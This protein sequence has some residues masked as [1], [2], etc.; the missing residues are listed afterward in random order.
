MKLSEDIEKL[1]Q[2]Q[3]KKELGAV[4]TYLGMAAH[5]ESTPYEGF[6][7]WMHKQVKEEMGHAMKF[8][9]YLK[10]RGNSIKLQ[11]I[12]APKCTFSSPLEAFEVALKHEQGVTKSI[13]NIYEA[14]QK[15]KDFAT[16]QFLDWFIKEQVEEESTASAFIQKLTIAKDHVGAL[17]GLDSQAGK[18][19]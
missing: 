5:F 4:Y 13:N 9:H 15:E 12:E 19:E 18:R 7:H 8:F 14:A 1:I 2:E 3:V 16:M 11:S 10:D 17:M 6:A